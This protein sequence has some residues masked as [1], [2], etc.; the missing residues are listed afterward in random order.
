MELLTEENAEK[1]K[2][3]ARIAAQALQYGAGLIKEGAVIREVC[4]AV[5]NKIISLGARP[6]WPTQAGLNEVAAHYTP[7]PDDNA[8]FKDEVVCLD[9]G[10][11]IDGCIGDNALTVDLSGKYTDL[12]R[13]A[14]DAFEA[15]QKE[16]AIG[17]KIAD[18]S[19]AIQET[20][21]SAGF[22]PVRNLSGHTISPWVIH[23]APSIPNTTTALQTE[24]V[25][26]QVIAIE[27]FATTG[28]G[29]V[30]EADRANLFALWNKRP[31]RSPYA[32]EALAYAEKEYQNLPF[33]T[34]W[35]A[36]K[37]GKGKAQFALK[38]LDE[39]GILHAYPPLVEKDKGIVAV[40][41][42]TLLV[43]EKVEV[44]TRADE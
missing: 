42:H 12:V 22:V 24:L 44:L 3:A 14:K 4:D 30:L 16:V 40:H 8:T 27:P 29:L 2:K 35:L 11:H 10:A 39:A 25:K 15:A 32:R 1:W 23:D 20:I 31:V 5:D 43:D 13:A 37:F 7:D 33:T 9:C 18:I 36:Q 28:A 26:G 21:T 41:E 19:K 34:R 38:A 6:A 17:A